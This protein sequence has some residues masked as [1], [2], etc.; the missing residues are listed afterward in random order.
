[1]F[2]LCFNS[3]S[4]DLGSSKL[5][6]I[7]LSLILILSP[8]FNFLGLTACY[9]YEQISPHLPKFSNKNESPTLSR[10]VPINCE[11]LNFLPFPI[12]TDLH[13]HSLLIGWQFC[14]MKN[15]KP[16]LKW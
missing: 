15:S 7:K 1:M 2:F 14:L 9:S 3:R 16:L 5:E 6:Q 10:E 4:R 11:H 8:N 12:A 13:F